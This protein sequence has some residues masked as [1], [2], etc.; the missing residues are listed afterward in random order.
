MS[1]F[2]ALRIFTLRTTTFCIGKMP[3]VA[4]SISLPI[5]SGM[6]F[7]T[8]SLMSH[9]DAS[10][11]TMSTIFLRICC[12]EEMERSEARAQGRKARSH[13]TSREQC[14]GGA[15]RLLSCRRASARDC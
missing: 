4:F 10:L 5:E 15:S 6:S 2:G 13:Q 1:S 3:P 11:V 7:C 12:G 8:S 14:S 9:E